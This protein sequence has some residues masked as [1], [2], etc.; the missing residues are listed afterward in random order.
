MRQ[1]A[2][3]FRLALLLSVI[4]LHAMA[5]G[6]QVNISPSE[7]LTAA[8]KEVPGKLL[9]NEMAEEGE[10]LVYR[11]KILT[12]QGVVKTVNVR[13]RDGGIVKAED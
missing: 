10:E 2:A 12:A 3:Q 1:I 8:Q 9:S 5:F 11:I 6:P 7:A 4:S 13:T